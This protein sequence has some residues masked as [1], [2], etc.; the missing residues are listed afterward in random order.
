MSVAP[1]IT[2][3]DT[4]QAFVRTLAALGNRPAL[5]AFHKSTVETW[6]FAEL[7]DA[8]TRL[9]SGLIEAGLRDG[10]PVAIYSPNRVEWII[11]CLALLDAGAIPVPI[12]SQMASD[13]LAHVIEDSAAHRLMTIRPL[14]DRLTTTGLHRDRSIILLDAGK[15]DPRS[16]RHFQREPTRTGSSVKPENHALMFYT[17][18]VSG[19]PKGVP[20]SH[21]NLMSNLRALLTT[22]V[23]RPDERLLLPLPLHHVYP[24][25][26]GLLAPFALGLPVILPHSLTG[27]QVLRALREGRVTAIVGVTRLYSALYATIEQQVRQKG[28][29]LS[30]AFHGLLALSALLIRYGNIRLGP[31]LFAPLRAHVAPELRTLVYGG[32]GL[33]PDLAW[34][35]AGLGWQIAGGFGLTET[36]PILTLIAPG[37]RHIDTA[38][39][40]LPGVRIRVADPDPA[41]GQGEIQALGPNVFAGY[42]HL[43]HKTVEAFTSDGWF[44]TG[45]LGSIDKNGCLHLAGRASSRITLPGGEKI[46]PERVED[47]L[48]GAP[49]IREAGVLAYEGRLVGVIVPRAA[50]IQSGERDAVTRL[51]RADIEACLSLQPSYCRLTEFT[52]SLDPLPRTRLGKIQRHKLNILFTAGKQRRDKVLVE[53]RPIPVELMAPEDRQLL[54]DPVV[55]RTWNWLAGRF[56]AVRLTPD[57]ALSLELGLDSLEWMSMTLELRDRAGVDL[58]EEALSRIGTV[59]DLLREAGEAEQAAGAAIDPAVQLANPDELIEPRQRRWLME[60]GWFLRGL[61][62]VLFGLDR[63]LLRTMFDLDIHGT[64]R[65]PAQGPCVLTPNHAS[66]LD[67]PALIAALP[68]DFVNRTYW[69][70]WT[71]IMFRDSVMRLVSRATRVFPVDQSRRPLANLGLGATV[72]ARGHNLVWF[73]EGSRSQDGT[74]RPFQPG[75][76]LILTAHPVP[77]VPV[78][79]KGSF[80]ALPPGAWWP[81]RRRI[82]IIFGRALNPGTLAGQREGADRYRQITAALHDHVARLDVHPE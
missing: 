49:S 9:A 79:I 69:G 76:G 38:G 77:V 2:G 17:S 60:R 58:P 64:E 70:G 37:S 41:S 82:T 46:W 44:R 13:D 73:P 10:E 66:L 15:D 3:P 20:L 14:A 19:R 54:D 81:R 22:Q 72:L 55:L 48:D 59:R 75:I 12:D 23:Y 7:A 32:A 61:G 62:T 1:P 6:S 36:S 43:P 39:T 40:P 21:R 45:D 74:L 34:R 29:I 63:L 35:L 27:P 42:L 31:R 24:F 8:A 4:L 53:S 26:V 68:A 47:I 11:A 71:G 56:P 50:A 16:W 57:T 25:M 78:R 30:A 67:A 18:G 52:L 28:R 5:L 65:I 80:E 51:I 33:P